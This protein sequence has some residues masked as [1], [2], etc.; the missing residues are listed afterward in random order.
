MTTISLPINLPNIE[1]INVTTL[2]NGDIIVHIKSTETGTEAT[3]IQ[4]IN[5]SMRPILR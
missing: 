1:I 5:L 4:L 2:D 3:W